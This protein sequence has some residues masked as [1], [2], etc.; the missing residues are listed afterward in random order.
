MICHPGSIWGRLSNAGYKRQHE[1]TGESYNK[2]QCIL[3]QC[4]VC[5]KPLQLTARSS[6][7]HLC[8]ML[9]RDASSVTTFYKLNCGDCPVPDCLY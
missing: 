9:G 5:D 3:V 8:R 7:V 2:R 1:G 6:Q 4:P